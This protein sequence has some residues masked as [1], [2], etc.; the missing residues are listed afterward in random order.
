MPKI[1]YA[2]EVDAH[3][4]IPWINDLK[5]EKGELACAL[6]GEEID[7]LPQERAETLSRLILDQPESEKEDPIQWGWTLPGWRRVMDNWK[8]TKINVV[9]AKQLSRPAFLCIWH[10]PFRKRRFVPCMYRRSEVLRMPKG[11]Y[12]KHFP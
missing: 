7:A 4:G 1:T 11:T 12:G 8:D 9:L 10:R 5:Y 6:S 3:F 2:D